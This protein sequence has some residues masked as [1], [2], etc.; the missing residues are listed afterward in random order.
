MRAASADAGI[1]VDPSDRFLVVQGNWWYRAEY[2]VLPADTGSRIE[3][4]VLNV[5]AK[6]HWAAPLAARRVLADSPVAF[7]RLLTALAHDLE[8]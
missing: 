3:H 5:G 2:R 8:H 6:A 7:G 4:E 1:A